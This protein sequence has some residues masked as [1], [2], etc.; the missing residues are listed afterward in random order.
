MCLYVSLIG[1]KLFILTEIHYSKLTIDIPK[2]WWTTVWFHFPSPKTLLA[3]EIKSRCSAAK[4]IDSIF[5]DF[6]AAACFV[7]GW[8]VE[9]FVGFIFVQSKNKHFLLWSQKTVISSDENY[10]QF[11]Y[12]IKNRAH[13]TSCREIRAKDLRL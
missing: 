11:W 2:V 3:V 5:S 4:S 13:Y 1:R 12:T 7:T 9:I 8:E 10:S 6:F